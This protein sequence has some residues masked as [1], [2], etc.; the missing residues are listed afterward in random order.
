[1]H[2]VYHIVDPMLSAKLAFIRRN[3]FVSLDILE[4]LELH[5]INVSELLQLV[6]SLDILSD[7]RISILKCMIYFL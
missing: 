6:S 4:T 1:M 2:V 5:V 3:V 7:T